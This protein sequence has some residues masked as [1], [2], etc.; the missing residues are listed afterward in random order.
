VRLETQRQR[1]A[2]SIFE[3]DLVDW[4]SLSTA[5]GATTRRRLVWLDAIRGFAVLAVLY[6][7]FSGA[8]LPEWHAVTAG[9]VD[10]N[11]LGL[12]LFFLVGGYVV[13]IALDRS[14]KQRTFWIGRV[15]RIWPAYLLT[16]AVTVLLGY[17]GLID[18]PRDKRVATLLAN[19]TTFQDLLGLPSLQY[20]TWILGYEVTFCVVVSILYA[21]RA[22]RFSA[23]IAAA[24]AAPLIAGGLLGIEVPERATRGLLILAIMCTGTATYR[25]ISGQINRWRAAVAVAAVLAAACGTAAN[26]AELIGLVAAA[27]VF[28]SGLLCRTTAPRW[29][30]PLGPRTNSL[31]LLHALALQLVVHGLPGF[32]HAS[33][34]IRLALAGGVFMALLICSSL[35]YRAVEL[36][37][38]HL[39]RILLRRGP[40]PDRPALRPFEE[41][42]RGVE[43]EMDALLLRVGPPPEG[44]RIPGDEA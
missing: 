19:L 22:H 2:P 32:G 10:G 26:R 17:A 8:L 37:A 28:A 43:A 24:L 21:V 15:L 11:V 38:Q 6:Q 29:L 12:T 27:V 39:G 13:P 16:I 9:W 5:E 25:A 31:Y 33:L 23:E 40:R 1:A 3:F 30:R 20:P 36:P 42:W 41:A 44:P 18:M 35:T 4:A 7:H 34:G 14:G